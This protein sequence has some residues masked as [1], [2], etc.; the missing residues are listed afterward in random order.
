MIIF[1]MFFFIILAM[2]HTDCIKDSN[3]NSLKQSIS[4]CLYYLI[5]SVYA[6]CCTW[7]SLLW[8][9]IFWLYLET[10]EVKY[11]YRR[12]TVYV[13]IQISHEGTADLLT[14]DITMASQAISTGWCLVIVIFYKKI[15]AVLIDVLA[16]PLRDANQI[17]GSIE[18]L[19]LL[20]LR[21]RSFLQDKLAEARSFFSNRDHHI[22]TALDGACK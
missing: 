20:V 10:R 2:I 8:Q 3:R 4:L 5:V 12:E 13:F 22:G 9:P 14:W 6:S 18:S 17:Y 21:N 7:F 15:Q 11:H 16:L 1:S 19:K